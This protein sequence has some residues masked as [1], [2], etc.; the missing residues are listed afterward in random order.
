M[1]KPYARTHSSKEIDRRTCF[2]TY[3]KRGALC[4]PP[5]RRIR[6]STEIDRDSCFG[7]GMSKR[8][9]RTA[10]TNVCQ[11]QKKYDPCGLAGHAKRKQFPEN[12][13]KCLVKL[14]SM[15][16]I[17]YNFRHLGGFRGGGRPPGGS[18][19]LS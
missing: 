13:F 2:E 15:F 11:T 10:K 18:R 1:R 14:F 7:K 3:I 6:F 8:T 4:A 9:K 19:G 16:T 17:V 12:P 5:M